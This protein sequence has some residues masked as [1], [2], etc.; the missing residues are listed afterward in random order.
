MPDPAPANRKPLALPEAP[1]GVPGGNPLREGST[2]WNSANEP[3]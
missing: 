3:S 1:P 2:E